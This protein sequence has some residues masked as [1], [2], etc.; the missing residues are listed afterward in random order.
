MKLRYHPQVVQKDIPKLDG[1]VRRRIRSAIEKKLKDHP[2]HFAKPLAYTRQG[3]WS[4]RVGDWRVLFTLRGESAWILRIG[5][6]RE[7]YRDLDSRQ[8]P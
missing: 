1:S 4:L 2:E 6:R 5:H 3:L 8:A 7:V